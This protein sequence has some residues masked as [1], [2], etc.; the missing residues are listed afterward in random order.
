M[1]VYL[2]IVSVSSFVAS[3]VYAWRT[4]PVGISKINNGWMVTDVFVETFESPEE[5]AANVFS[6]WSTVIGLSRSLA[7]TFER[8]IKIRRFNF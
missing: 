4:R 3:F 2:A 6:L 8:L 5:P 7:A 1:I